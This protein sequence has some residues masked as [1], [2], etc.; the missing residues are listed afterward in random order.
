MYIPIGNPAAWAAVRG[1]EAYP[2]LGG[3]VHFYPVE[4]GT[5]VSA[6]I[7]GL[8][9]SETG[10]FAFHIHE[11]GSCAEPGGHFDTAGRPHP[12]HA[13]DL[14][15]L[16]SAGGSARMTVLTDRFRPEDVTGRTAVIHA[17]PDDFHTQPAGNPGERIA[18][19][20]IRQNSADDVVH[21]AQ[22]VASAES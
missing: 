17:G 6:E 9:Q 14:P 2:R 7:F 13:G 8:P 11:G 5:L 10:F 20:V 1:G 18:C 22:T 15:P 3:M 19:G 12:S 4:G 16:L 21:N